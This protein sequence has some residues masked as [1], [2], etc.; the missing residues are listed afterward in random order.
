MQ[1]GT[2]EAGES[3]PQQRFLG[4]EANLL[5]FAVAKFRYVFEAVRHQQPKVNARVGFE[6]TRPARRWS[7]RWQDCKY[8][9]PALIKGIIQLAYRNVPGG[10]D[11]RWELVDV[12][13]WWDK[14]HYFTGDHLLGEPR[15]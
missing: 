4:L 3:Q 6:T 12:V 1:R 9:L 7:W 8:R 14:E 5:F 15:R 13:I 10:S 2:K 11:V